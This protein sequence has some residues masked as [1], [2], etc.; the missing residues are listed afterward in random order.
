MAIV[1]DTPWNAVYK[2]FFKFHI[3]SNDVVHW[4]FGCCTSLTFVDY[5]FEAKI[6]SLSTHLSN[7]S[8]NFFNI[9]CRRMWVGIGRTWYYHIC[10]RCAW[11]RLHSILLL[12]WRWSWNHSWRFLWLRGIFECVGL[13]LWA[14]RRVWST[15]NQFTRKSHC[16]DAMTIYLTNILYIKLSNDT[17][18]HRVY[19]S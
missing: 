15:I 7:M 17:F 2:V 19:F 8:Q 10:W 12:S 9:A 6:L 5:I 4:F 18:S 3:G 1:N 13:S 11:Y 14:R 16:N